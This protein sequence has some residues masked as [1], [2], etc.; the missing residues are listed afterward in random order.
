MVDEGFVLNQAL[1]LPCG[2]VLK[3]RMVK[4]AMSEG[5]ADANNCV[6]DAHLNLYKRWATN[7]YGLM[8]S[9]NVQIDRRFLERPGNIA[10]D[11]NGGFQGLKQLAAL[12]TQNQAH[13]WMQINHPGR[14][15]PAG[16]HAEP[17]APSAIPL[18]L[19]AAD[20]GDARA[21][22]KAD[23]AD[24]IKRFVH[25]A[26]I[27]RETGFSGVQIHAAHGYLLSNFLSPLANKRDDE[28]GGSLANRARL[29]LEV[30]AA[31][32]A[33][34]GAAFPI[35]VKLNSADFQRGGFCEEESMQVVQWLSAAGIDLLEISG[36]SYEQ[37]SMVGVDSSEPSSASSQKLASTVAREAYFLT[38]AEK[39][40]PLV[41]MPLMI[42]GGFR[43]KKGMSDALLSG[44]CELIG[45]GRPFCYAPDDCGA[46][47]T[48]ATTE[49]FSAALPSIEHDLAMASDALGDG[50]DEQTFKTAE[51]FGLLAW[52][53][54]QLMRVAKGEG[55]DMGLG[56]YDALL[57]YKASEAAALAAWRRP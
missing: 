16:I 49:R 36:G 7:D 42:T 20:C 45:V 18:P 41:N 31:M 51:S 39:V 17:L 40:R 29:L 6:S 10:I 25:V 14:Q 38:F 4:A 9:G 26:E 47:L 52:Y 33:A 24:V 48:S 53:C 55:A 21:M 35:S 30:V 34:L 50:V 37:M 8:I 22:T 28:Y 19:K 5:L 1:R 15:T 13:F 27:A 46:I 54:L 23:I 43:G 12:G 56:V 2:V 11:G 57:E 32:R 44:A 3:N